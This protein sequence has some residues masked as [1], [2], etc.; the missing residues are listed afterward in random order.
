MSRFLRIYSR[1]VKIADKLLVSFRR[2]A[3]RN[4]DFT[5]ICN[6]CWAGYVYR[7]F[8][9]PYR[10]PTVGLYFFADDFVKLCADL[11][12]YMEMPLEFIPHTESKHAEILKQRDHTHIP[13]G[14]LGDIEVVFLHYKTPEEAKDKWDRRA[15]RINY[16]NLIFK[17]SKMNLCST[18]ALKAFDS[19]ECNKK[20]CFVPPEDAE[21]IECAISVNS[22]RGKTEIAND[23][24]TY[25][26]FINLRKMINAE[27][28]C[29][30][31]ME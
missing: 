7:R 11:R 24:A 26:H 28:V 22:A 6:N 1:A 9:I 20:F 14:K 12:R 18:E 13:I 4:D 15:K 19:L 25:A 30:S 21:Q 16:D 8:G 5:I 3:I 23:T 2:R 31:H 10:T 17:F 29:G 27:K